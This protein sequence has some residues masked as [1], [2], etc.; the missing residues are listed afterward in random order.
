[1]V[2]KLVEVALNKDAYKV[3]FEVVP[4]VITKVDYTDTEGV[5][6]REAK[7]QLRQWY[8]NEAAVLRKVSEKSYFV[9]VEEGI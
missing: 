6:W 9:V 4:P 1:M 7:K 2:H 5:S 8:L 3:N